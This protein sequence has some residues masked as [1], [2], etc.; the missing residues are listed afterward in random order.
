LIWY[1]NSLTGAAFPAFM[2]CNARQCLSYLRKI[3]SM[4]IWPP[5]IALSLAGSASTIFAAERD[6]RELVKMPAPMQQ[7]LLANMRDHLLAITEIQQALSAGEYDR[8]ADV[9]EK[10][11]GMSSMST[12][13]A[14]HMAP[15]M[16]K[17]MQEIGSQMHKAAS[18][19][20][21]IAQETAV[22]GNLKRAIGAVSTITQQCVACHASYRAH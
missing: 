19:F 13:G 5:L 10:R 4:S 2:A 20:A 15:F 6:A 18:R 21:V 7:H 12:H 16:P 11:I 1:S 14:S 3:A 17:P 22:D 9:A 8:A